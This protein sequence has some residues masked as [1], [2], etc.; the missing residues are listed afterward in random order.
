M[1]KQNQDDEIDK[2]SKCLESLNCPTPALQYVK[3][4]HIDQEQSF[5]FFDKMDA[6]NLLKKYYTKI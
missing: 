3:F 4:L 6:Y 2:V 1:S 5:P